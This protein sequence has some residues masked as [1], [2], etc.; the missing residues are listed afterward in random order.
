[1]FLHN[2]DIIQDKEEHPFEQ[3]SV[4]CCKIVVIEGLSKFMS[5]LQKN[6]TIDWNVV[7]SKAS[8]N[9]LYVLVFT[10]CR[11]SD[12]FWKASKIFS[13]LFFQVA[14]VLPGIL[15]WFAKPLLGLP[16]SSSFNASCFTFRATS[17]CFLFC[18]HF[19]RVSQRFQNIRILW[20]SNWKIRT[21]ESRISKDEKTKNSNYMMKKTSRGPKQLFD[22]DDF[23]IYVSS[24]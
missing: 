12:E 2:V 17:W 3:P 8:F 11:F 13:L 20:H 9:F 21:Y 14:R 19:C 4:R 23:S 1:M 18:G 16:F 24:N 10:L 7:T 6:R 5:F 15:K 22:L